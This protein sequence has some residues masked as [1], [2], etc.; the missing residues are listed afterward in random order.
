MA[1]DRPLDES[2]LLRKEPCPKCG[3]RLV[4]CD[5]NRSARAPS[6]ILSA[7][8][9]GHKSAIRSVAGVVNRFH[10]S[11][12]IASARPLSFVPVEIRRGFPPSSR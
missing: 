6:S 8:Y 11:R 12:A 1:D 10:S 4:Q 3:S 2:P 9:F 7:T 5:L